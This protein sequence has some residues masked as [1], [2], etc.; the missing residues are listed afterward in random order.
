M[1]MIRD[2]VE[3]EVKDSEIRKFEAKGFKTIG[4]VS[5]GSKDEGTESS[6]SDAIEE[7]T[8][9]KLKELAKKTGIEGYSSM[10][11]EELIE[12]LNEVTE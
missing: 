5:A 6:G 8:V 9:S 7:M 2:N 4:S 11:K 3:R 12:A 10:K 1:R